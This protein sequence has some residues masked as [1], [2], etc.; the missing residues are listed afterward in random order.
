MGGQR[1][2]AFT[3]IELL[4]VIGI[5]GV[6]I[7]LLLPAVQK[8]REAARRTSCENNLK[9]MGLALLH[10]HN[11]YE[12]FPP[13]YIFKGR[14]DGS[15]PGP[16]KFIT[17]PGWGWGA[18]LLPYL[19]Q[20]PLASQIDWTVPLDSPRYQ[21]VRTTILSVFVCASDQNTGV[22]MVR[23][24]LEEDL[25]QVAT[26]SYAANYGTNGEIGEHPYSSDGLFYCN[27]KIRIMEV[28][29]G[30][31]NTL[32]IGERCAYFARTPWVGAVSAGAVEINPDGPVS[33]IVKEEAPVQVMAGVCNGIPLN[34]DQSN[35]YCFYSPHRTV[36]QF[37]FA[38]GSA[39]ALSINTAYKVLE[40]LATRD[41]GEAINSGDF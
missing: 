2:P 21:H 9:Q 14:P 17:E 32:A 25:V 3:L 30:L 23:N 40:A 12:S 18:L 8:V 36:V 27:S 41:G 1:R 19:E 11:T 31:S 38:D 37:A 34:D 26:N 20:D 35:P 5:I 16:V 29:D 28:T 24:L 22:Y 13:A 6:L 10:Y 39:H 4:V 33:N 7:A 15:A